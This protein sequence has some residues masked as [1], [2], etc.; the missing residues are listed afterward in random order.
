MQLLGYPEDLSQQIGTFSLSML[1]ISE[2]KLSSEGQFIHLKG[3]VQKILS[4]PDVHVTP[5]FPERLLEDCLRGG[6]SEK[7]AFASPNVCLFST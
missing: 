1:I 7:G 6:K 2:A 3:K 5:A 4:E